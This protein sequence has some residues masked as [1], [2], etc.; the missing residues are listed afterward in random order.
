V[1]FRVEQTR[2]AGCSRPRPMS[3][4]LQLPRGSKCTTPE[5]LLEVEEYFTVGTRLRPGDTV[6]DAGAN[7]GAF[8]LLAA[9][10]CAGDIRLLC[11]EPSP[12]TYR[13]LEANFAREP[14]LRKARHSLHCLGLTSPEHAGLERSFY[15]FRR[16]PRNSTFDL[17][18]KRREFEIFFEDRGSRLRRSLVGA[19]GAWSGPL[20]A[21]LERAISA[22]PRGPVAWWASR[23]IMGFEEITARLETLERVLVE[24]K[25]ERVDLLKIDVEGPELDVLRGLGERSWPLVRQVVMETHNRDGRQLEIEDLLARH[26]L[27]Q[28]TARVQT[29]IDNGLESLLLHARR[30]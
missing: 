20:G 19:L 24:E 28:I 27:S 1:L 26:G 23:Q 14:L 8:A 17:S 22:I 29:T 2:H 3:N 9:Q 15:N 4:G 12:E 25:V 11:F 21:S 6:I 10:R 30:P 5:L 16:D 7:M 18:A 13:A